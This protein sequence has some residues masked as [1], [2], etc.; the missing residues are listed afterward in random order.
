MPFGRAF[1]YGQQGRPQG[2]RHGHTRGFHGSDVGD[3]ACARAQHARARPKRAQRGARV[4]G[5]NGGGIQ[6]RPD[7]S[8]RVCD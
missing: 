7:L 5:R 1:K 4:G 8:I 6:R 2:A 3:D